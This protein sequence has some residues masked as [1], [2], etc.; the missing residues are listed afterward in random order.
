MAVSNR[1]TAALTPSRNSR[2]VSSAR[3]VRYSTGVA[4][5]GRGPRST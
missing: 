4:M 1:G 5:S 3:S 2:A